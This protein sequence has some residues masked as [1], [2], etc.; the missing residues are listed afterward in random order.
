MPITRPALH[1]T[2]QRPILVLSGIAAAIALIVALYFTWQRLRPQMPRMDAPT[3]V[4]ARYVM[5]EHFEQQP[6]DM[7]A[8]FMKLLETRQET[9]K[10]DSNK[11]HELDKAF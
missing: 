1:R 7:Q 6:F 3:P 5:T 4:I 10:K 9:D 2:A 11:G 8:Q